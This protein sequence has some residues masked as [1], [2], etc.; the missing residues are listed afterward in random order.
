MGIALGAV[1]VALAALGGLLWS[2][3]SPGPVDSGNVDPPPVS[4]VEKP[5]VDSPPESSPPPQADPAANA[6]TRAEYGFGALLAVKNTLAAKEAERWGQP[7]WSEILQL[8]RDADA[9]IIGQDYA[10]AAMA[11]ETAKRTADR[12]VDSMPDI[13]ERLVAEGESALA[14][15]DGDTAMEKFETAL[16]ITPEHQG[17]QKSY[18]RAQTL[19]E[20]EKLV[21]SGARHEDNEKFAL[22]YADYQKALSLD[23]LHPAARDGLLRVGKKIKTD[24]FNALMSQGMAALDTGDL[25]TARDR[26]MTAKSF[27][28]HAPAVLDALKQLEEAVLKSKI[29]ALHRKALAAEQAEAWDRALNAYG[30]VLRLDPT[31]QFAIQ[32]RQRAQQYLYVSKRL[33]YYLDHPDA[34]AADQQL[35]NALALKADMA[36]MNITGSDFRARIQRFEEILKAA[37]TPVRIIIESDNLTRVT[38]YRV[39]KLGHFQEHRLKLRPGVYTVVGS[40]DGYQ[41]VRQ[42]LVVTSGQTEM[43]IDIR[44]VNKL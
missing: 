21:A 31:V 29:D 23:A 28:P 39:G 27:Q 9:M 6:R 32:G 37:Q 7:A 42:K 4:R 16:L 34:L 12:L 38:V 15:G 3:F 2:R 41:D 36:V 43:R 11:Y 18:K 44:C 40:R 24:R 1:L 13:F 33:D 14:R 17:T 30:A 8:N 25:K 5:V 22:A 19:D 26:L 35:Q 20:V 10:G